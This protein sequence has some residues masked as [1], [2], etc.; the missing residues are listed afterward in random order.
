MPSPSPAIPDHTSSDITIHADP[1]VTTIRGDPGSPVT[2]TALSIGDP[3]R[4][5]TAL[6]TGD[7]AKPVAT[8]SVGDPNRPV[9]NMIQ[10]DPAKPIVTQT[11]MLNLPRLTLQDLKELVTPRVRIQMPQYQ[12]V[13]IRIM[14]VEVF[15]M[16]TSGESQ[17]I[18]G[19]YEPNSLERCQIGCEGDDRRPFPQTERHDNG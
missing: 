17:V 2:T 10:G 9:T 19:P 3:A 1:T 18:S 7:P 13:C 12:Q 11:E 8:L 5:T 15:S 14:G 4:P 16:C 6:I